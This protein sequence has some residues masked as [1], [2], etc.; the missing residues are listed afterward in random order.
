MANAAAEGQRIQDDILRAMTPERKLELA[1]ELYWSARDLK[2][3]GLRR[4]HP[5]WSQEQ[6][7]AAVREVF[8]Y[9]RS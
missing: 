2:A 1:M 4:Q 8:M 7:Q 9:A 6:V 5:D 3:A